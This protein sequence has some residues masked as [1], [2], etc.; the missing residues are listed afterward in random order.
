VAAARLLGAL[1]QMRSRTGAS[2]SQMRCRS[3]IRYWAIE[4]AVARRRQKLL[5]IRGRLLHDLGAYALQDVTCRTIRLRTLPGPY[6]VPALH[7]D[8]TVAATN[9]TPVV[10]GARCGLPRS[11][12]SAMERL[13][14][15]VARELKL[16]RAEVRR[17]KPHSGGQEC[18]YK[19]PLKARSGL[20]LEYD[21]GD[22]PACQA[23]VL[24]AAAWDDFPHRQ[25]A[26]A[27]AGPLHRHRARARVSKAP[28]A[29]RSN[30][31]WWRDRAV[32]AALGVSPAPPRWG[33]G[34]RTAL[35]QICAHELGIRAEDVQ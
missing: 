12:R 34:V 32:R 18:R 7:M 35:A 2:T 6:M 27:R 28:A 13:L 24:A 3:V 11:G 15:R 30:R 20:G 1:D 23:Q 22:Y 14:D 29:G 8:V 25:R 17:R 5:G 33:R 9:K 26:G 31:P 19:K 16:D 10:L 4:I 21:S